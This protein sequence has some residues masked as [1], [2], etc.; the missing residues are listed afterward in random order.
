MINCD[1]IETDIFVGSCPASVI[2]IDRLAGGMKVTAILCLQ[3]DK[4]FETYHLPIEKIRDACT[5]LGVEWVQR[6]V[7]DF[8]PEDMARSIQAPVDAL[9]ELLS[10]GKRVYVHCTAG[11]CRA[12]GTVVGYLHKYR[13]KSLEEAMETVKSKRPIANP[14]M[15]AL[16]IAFNQDDQVARRE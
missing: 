2:D 8:D 7:I 14:Y 9:N 3:S 4:D 11:I 12:P 16:K 15:E 6:P 13:G 1:R 10:A 5:Q